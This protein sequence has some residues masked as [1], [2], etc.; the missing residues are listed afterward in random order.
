M[1]ERIENPQ[2]LTSLFGDDFDFA[3]VDLHEVVVHRDGPTIRLRF[4]LPQV[5]EVPPSRWPK[6]ANTTQ[7]V[8]LAEAIDALEISGFA[9]ECTGVLQ[10]LT[11]NG[12][13]ILEFSCP[14][15]S[16]RF[17]YAWL[18]ITGI[19]GYVNST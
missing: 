5:P 19:S 15:S 1:I 7:V 4:D 9:T 2:S 16:I 10:A 8:L 13:K 17:A 12:R 14:A 11:E 3:E 6:G 18:R